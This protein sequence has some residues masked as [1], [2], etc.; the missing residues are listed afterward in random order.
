MQQ[1]T[2]YIR[3][4]YSCVSRLS[5]I[6]GVRLRG[7]WHS[8]VASFHLQSHNHGPLSA[9]HCF[10]FLSK[11]SGRRMPP[12]GSEAPCNRMRLCYD[13]HSMYLVLLY[14]G[15]EAEYDEYI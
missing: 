10:S 14:M 6:P 11:R 13:R 8:Q 4:I 5:C 2:K 15:T 1:N 9:S 7:S 3:G 12:A